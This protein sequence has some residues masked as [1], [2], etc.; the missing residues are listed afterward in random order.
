MVHP[1]ITQTL[2]EHFLMKGSLTNGFGAVDPLIGLRGHLILLRRLHIAA[3]LP[4]GRGG[5][6]GFITSG[7]NEISQYILNRFS[8]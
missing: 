3:V 7:L 6:T 2:F 4:S 5:T 8:T 1:S